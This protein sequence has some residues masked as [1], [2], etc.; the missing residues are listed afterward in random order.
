LE[1]VRGAL[2]LCEQLI[3]EAEGNSHDIP[4][5]GIDEREDRSPVG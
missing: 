5:V 1:Q 4:A 3:Q 2:A